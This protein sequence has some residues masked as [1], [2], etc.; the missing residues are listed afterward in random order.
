M[1]R[2]DEVD[3][4]VRFKGQMAERSEEVKRHL[5]V[6]YNTELIR[7]LVNK[8]YRKM[9]ETKEKVADDLK[10]LAAILQQQFPPEFV[11][12]VKRL[13]WRTITLADLVREWK[14]WRALGRKSYT[15]LEN[16]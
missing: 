13:P 11:A 2:E 8:E 7:V 16:L 1:E 5:G 14:K 10:D 6:K 3:I 12:H 4:A 9:M 15:E